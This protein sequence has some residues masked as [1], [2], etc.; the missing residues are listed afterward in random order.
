MSRH[1]LTAVVCEHIAE[2]LSTVGASGSLLCLEEPPLS[3]ELYGLNRL[4][5]CQGQTP[6]HTRRNK[7]KK[8]R[9]TLTTG[10]CQCHTLPAANSRGHGLRLIWTIRAEVLRSQPGNVSPQQNTLSAFRHFTSP[11]LPANVKRGYADYLF[12]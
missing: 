12:R 6:A 10:Q 1:V 9:G 11:C 4:I 8:R 5:I 3:T 7:K 2:A